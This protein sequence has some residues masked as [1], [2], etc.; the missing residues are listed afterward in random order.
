MVVSVNPE[1]KNEDFND[2]LDKTLMNLSI[3]SNNHQDEYL[4]LLGS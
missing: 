1:P 4:T 3:E 2:L